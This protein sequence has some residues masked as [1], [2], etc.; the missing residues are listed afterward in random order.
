M[1]ERSILANEIELVN[2]MASSC[3]VLWLVAR[4][5]QG[6][7]LS[8]PD[9]NLAKLAQNSTLRTA[10]PGSAET[11]NAAAIPTLAAPIE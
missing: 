7:E 2:H 9:V 6:S 3:I 8:M 5:C 10:K 1:M 11:P 4:D